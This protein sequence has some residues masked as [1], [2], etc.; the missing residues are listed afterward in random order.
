M[1]SAEEWARYF[2]EPDCTEQKRSNMV[3]WLWRIQRDAI[4]SAALA[5]SDG[6]VTASSLERIRAL[7]PDPKAAANNAD[8]EGA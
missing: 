1:R 7:L 8:G 5:A 4:Q 2:V 6:A 3:F